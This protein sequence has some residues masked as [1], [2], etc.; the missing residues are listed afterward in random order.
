[1][2]TAGMEHR[3]DEQ[4]ANDF[5]F[6][7][8]IPFVIEVIR[9]ADEQRVSEVALQGAADLFLTLGVMLYDADLVDDLVE[10]INDERS[11]LLSQ[12]H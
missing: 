8:L 6:E 4:M 11:R 12:T 5:K 10:R 1:M 3:T 7:S 2:S 9:V